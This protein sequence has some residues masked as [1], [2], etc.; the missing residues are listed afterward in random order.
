ML[1]KFAPLT[2]F[3]ALAVPGSASAA[4][5]TDISYQGNLRFSGTPAN[6]LFDFQF[7]LYDQPAS[8]MPLVCAADSADVPVEG[9]LFAV[10]LDFGGAVFAGEER[11]LEVRVRPGADN[12]G[13][14]SLL[15]RQRVRAA[16]EALHAAKAPWSGL[17][18]VPAGLADGNDDRGVYE[19]TAGSGLSGGP[20]TTSGSLSIAPAGV[21]SSMLAESA[22]GARE[23]ADNAV[24]TA[25]LVDASVTR[26]KLA[27]QAVGAGQID[28]AL[29]QTRVVGTCADGEYMRGVAQD[30]TVICG[31]PASGITRV[32]DTSLAASDPFAAAGADYVAMLLRADD[33]PLI[34]Y[35]DNVNLDLKLYDCANAACASG[36]IRTLDANGDVGQWVSIARRPDGRPVIVYQYNSTDLRFYDCANADCTSGSARTL[37]STNVVGGFADVA[38]RANGNPVIAYYDQTLSDMRVMLCNDSSCNSSSIAI[39]GSDGWVGQANSIVVHPGGDASIAHYEVGQGQLRVGYCPN[40]TCDPP[41]DS[42]HTY[43]PNG[44]TFY[45]SM[46]L[47]PNGRPIFAFYMN[48][49]QDLDL[50]DC[51]EP[52]CRSASPIRELDT[53]GAVGEHPSLAVRANGIPVI[54][55]YDRTNTALKLYRCDDDGCAAGSPVV[56]DDNG[57]VGHHSS[58]AVRTDGRPVIAYWDGSRGA[59]KLHI[60]GN[61]E[62]ER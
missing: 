10:A 19:V 16:P 46:A 29:V 3:A 12:G 13:Y 20:I 1:N 30:G 54:S 59:L 52:S 23:L 8:V 35:Y 7:C 48:A 15:P 11:W 18:G 53:A 14:T 5:G 62:C 49:T 57:N 36:T 22:V 34:A 28:P 60:C 55:Y 6:G 4:L 47:R 50:V 31:L 40:T 51:V 42:I 37:D 45:T 17:I 27:P 9:G 39:I 25:A 44:Q 38:V 43:A 61:T 41:Y 26:A 2:L 56:I 33:R 32:L 24:D 21:V 58:L